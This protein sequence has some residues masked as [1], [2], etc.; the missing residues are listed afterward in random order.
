M[1]EL[2]R[3]VRFFLYEIYERVKRGEV[4]DNFIV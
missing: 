3:K 2:F 4:Y 1:F